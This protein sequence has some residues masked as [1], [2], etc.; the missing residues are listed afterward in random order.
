MAEVALRLNTTSLETL[1]AQTTPQMMSQVAY[2]MLIFP[3][4]GETCF[5]IME[6]GSKPF[7]EGHLVRISDMRRLY[8]YREPDLG[9][10]FTIT[11]RT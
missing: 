6:T 9:G 10:W 8:D 4:R 3:A 7:A 5:Y 1:A 11:R 2:T